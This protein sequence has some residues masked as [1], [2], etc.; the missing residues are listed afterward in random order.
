MESDPNFVA[1]QRLR[2]RLHKVLR[3]AG[4]AK[5]AST[6]KLVGC[7]SRQLAAHLEAQFLP[8][9]SWGNRSKWHVDHIIPCAHFDLTNPDQQKECFHYS[10]LRPIWAADNIRKGAG[11]FEPLRRGGGHQLTLLVA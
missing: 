11:G 1:K 7:T 3:R 9:M 5:A 4:C 8:G 10:N 2:T 6:M